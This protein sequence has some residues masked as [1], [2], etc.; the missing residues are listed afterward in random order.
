MTYIY[1]KYIPLHT[2]CR[3]III[4]YHSIQFSSI[5]LSY[6]CADPTAARPITD[7]HSTDIHNYITPFSQSLSF[8]VIALNTMDDLC[9]LLYEE[10][11]LG[12]GRK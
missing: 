6:L 9:S 3:I 10:A 2:S 7:K 12:E 4:T 1:I 5:Q 11:H 8:I